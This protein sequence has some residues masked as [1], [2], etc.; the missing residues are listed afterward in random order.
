MIII[1]SKIYAIDFD[2]TL[3]QSMYPGIGSA[4]QK[5][6]DFVKKLREQGSKT[7][8]WT[9]RTDVILKE[10]VDWCK[11]NGLE[12]DAVNENIQESIDAYGGDTRKVYADF[13]IDDK[14]LAIA[15]TLSERKK[16][17]I[18]KMKRN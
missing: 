17:L 1:D 11:E 7:I 10:A 12:F 2:G 16:A 6:I 14:N 3:C 13:Y 15:D 8:L 9:C 18:E 4:I 5:N